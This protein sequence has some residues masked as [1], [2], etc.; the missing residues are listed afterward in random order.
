MSKTTKIRKKLEDI[1][2]DLEHNVTK[3]YERHD[4]HLLYD[5]AYH[6]VIQFAFMGQMLRRGW[7]E[8]LVVGDTRCGKTRTAERLL[9]HYAAGEMGT[10]ENTSLAGLIGGMQQISKQW[11]II[12][13]KLPRNDRRLVV[14]DEASTLPLDSIPAF[15]TIRSEGVARITKIQSEQTPARTRA[16]WIS[17]PRINRLSGIARPVSSYDYGILTVP[18]L[19]GRPADIARFDAAYVVANGEVSTDVIFRTERPEVQ[20]K[21]T[22]TLAHNLVMWAWSRRP[23]DVYIAKETER[24][25]LTV[26]KNLA[27]KYHDSIPLIK[28]EEAPEKIARLSVALAARVFSTEDGRQLNVLP[29]HVRYIET[30]LDSIYSRPIVGFSDFSRKLIEANTVL[31]EDEIIEAIAPYGTDFIIGML[32]YDVVRQNIVEDLTGLTRDQVRAFIS[33]LV[34]NR[35][36]RAEQLW[37]RKT[38]PFIKLLKDIECGKK[39]AKFTEGF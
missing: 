22:S 34:R 9:R 20:H 10:G 38:Q 14:I 39:K 24:T 35:C 18:E 7:V 2:T 27:S 33:K 23:E 16:I 8:V 29:E 6:S 13:G 12:W 25:I 17:N 19:I 15:A 3:I 28:L 36:L 31:N 30:F 21:Y 4:L 32:N 5:L 37:Y 26:A 1:Y 11:S